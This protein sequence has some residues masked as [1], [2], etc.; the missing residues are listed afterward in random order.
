LEINTK[1][2]DTIFAATSSTFVIY[3]STT[4]WENLEITHQL[5]NPVDFS[6]TV[7][8][9]IWLQSHWFLAR[10]LDLKIH[11]IPLRTSDPLNLLVTD[12]IFDFDYAMCG[13]VMEINCMYPEAQLANEIIFDNHTVYS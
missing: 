3:H 8:N 5:Q 9:P 6:L 2:K 13:W 10:N 1:N 4:N 7:F 12:V 11:G